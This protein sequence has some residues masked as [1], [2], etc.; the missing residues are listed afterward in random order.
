MNMPGLAQ[1][2]REKTNIF[3]SKFLSVSHEFLDLGLDTIFVGTSNHVDF[4]T[5]LEEFEGWHGLNFGSC[6]SLLIGVNIDLDEKGLFGV[7]VSPLFKERLD[8]LARRTPGGSE[9]NDN[10][11]VRGGDSSVVLIESGKFLNHF[12]VNK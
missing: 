5:S 11:F 10:K 6:S 4:D 3:F 1:N 2:Q 12:F 7:G 8:H 9:V